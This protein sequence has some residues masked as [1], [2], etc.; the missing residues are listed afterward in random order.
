MAR[1]V[2]HFSCGAASA[3]ATKMTLDANHGKDIVIFYAETGAEDHD[4][5]RFLEDCQGWFGRSVTRLCSEKYKDTWD[6]WEKK[7]YI[8][9]VKGAPCTTELK[10]K[11]RLLAQRP[12]DIHVF[13][14]TSDSSDMRRAEAFREHWPEMTIS[15]PL[16][17]AGVS[18]KACL[19]IIINVGIVP[20]RTYA[21]GFP[22]ANCIPCVK[23]Q[24]PSYWALVRQEYP[25]EFARMTELSHRFGAKLARLKVERIF[26][27][28]IPSDFPTV[29][30]IA[31][32]CDFLCQMVSKD[33]GE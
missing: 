13:G 30:P 32:E 10:V 3:V 1:I 15:T 26:I 9:G 31:P 8:S 18:K 33:L 20:P 2:C 28:D 7:R 6:V 29:D 11:P 19:A 21:M 25:M 14:Y 12:D 17:D 24:S 27:D 4:N 5:A 22:N 16:I 23:A